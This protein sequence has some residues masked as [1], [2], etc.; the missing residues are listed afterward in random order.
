VTGSAGL[1]YVEFVDPQGPMKDFFD[2]IAAAA[3]GWD[4]TDPIR[5]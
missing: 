2:M 4:G 3:D 1:P 5:G